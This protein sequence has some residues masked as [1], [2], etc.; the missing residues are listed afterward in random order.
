MACVVIMC[1]HCSC[2]FIQPTVHIHDLFC[3]VCF[4]QYVG[5]SHR[6]RD[7]AAY[8]SASGELESE[9]NAWSSTFIRAYTHEI[10]VQLF[11]I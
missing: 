11:K 3:T 5:H 2:I 8:A 10:A 7:D 1:A 9:T 6:E 4:V